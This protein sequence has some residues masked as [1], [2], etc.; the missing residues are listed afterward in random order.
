[1]STAASD[2]A[3][4]NLQTFAGALGGATAPAVTVGGRGFQVDG[5]DSFLN[6]AA[7]LGRSC[8]IQH[9]KCADVANSAAGRSSG[10]TVSQCD[11]QNTQC[12]AAIQ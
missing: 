8:D 5:S 1:V 10:L 4:G 6:S 9:N 2:V 11:Q 7:A 3:S 12:H